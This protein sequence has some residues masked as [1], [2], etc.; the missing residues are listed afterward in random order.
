M[1][2]SAFLNRYSITV[3]TTKNKTQDVSNLREAFSDVCRTNKVMKDTRDAAF[4][5]IARYKRKAKK[6]KSRL[7]IQGLR[8]KEAV[9]AT[10]KL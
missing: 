10:K 4:D 2:Q 5:K 9:E 3:I 8:L 7:R 6:Y 1:E